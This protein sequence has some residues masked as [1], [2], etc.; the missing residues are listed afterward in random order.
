MHAFS[1]PGKALVA[2]GYLVLDPTYP[3]FVTALLARMHAVSSKKDPTQPI[4]PITPTTTPTLSHSITICLPQFKRGIWTYS[5]GLESPQHVVEANGNFNPFAEAAVATVLSYVAPSTPVSLDINV[6]SD[7]GYHAQPRELL[8]V[9]SLAN[10]AKR[11]TYHSKPI[12]QVPKTGLGLSA[13]LVTV[14][15][16][17]MLAHL[18]VPKGSDS[19]ATVHNLAQIAHCYAQKK[20]GLGFDVAAAVYGSIIYQRFPP[21]PLQNLFVHAA[22]QGGAND[23]IEADVQADYSRELRHL[24]DHEWAFKHEKCALPPHIRLVIG[25]I[26]GGLLTPKLVA[27][28]MLWRHENPAEALAVYTDLDNANRSAMRA[29]AS[30]TSFY[31]QDKDAYRLAVRDFL[32]SGTTASG[33]FS[34]LRAAICE[35]RKQLQ[36]LLRESGADIEPPL[37]TSL[38]D[39]CMTLDGCIGGVVP[40]AGGFDAICLLMIDSSADALLEST[41]N[42]S[43]F[44]QVLWLDLLEQ[45]SGL[46][47]EATQDYE[48][49]PSSVLLE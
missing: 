41:C 45:A 39:D 3:A 44:S 26:H 10:G 37:Q 16:A 24:V 14:V 12:E 43:R 40:G 15:V 48:G 8:S 4:P 38:L 25:D 46:V 19:Q 33:P 18:G 27:T 36:R 34:D 9:H 22:L 13:G 5:A 20:V 31:E 29:L 42:D 11:F 30:L 32:I 6:Y 1:A 21:E 7:P 17:S 2:G 23:V 35:I 49:L 28:V 47:E